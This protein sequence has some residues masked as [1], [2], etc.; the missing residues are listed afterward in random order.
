MVMTNNRIIGNRAY[1]GG[2][3]TLQIVS[4]ISGLTFEFSHNEVRNNT[5][6]Q[7]GAGIAFDVAGM[8]ASRP[9]HKFF[10]NTFVNNRAHDSSTGPFR[11]G[12]TV[13]GAFNA[14]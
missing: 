7:M 8:K 11:L 4:S 14:F 12:T 13:G 5:A 6:L 1:E 2:G 3:I 9:L 10:N